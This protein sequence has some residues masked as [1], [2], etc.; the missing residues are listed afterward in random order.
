MTDTTNIKSTL[1]DVKTLNEALVAKEDCVV[2]DV[3][4]PEEF[5]RGKILGGINLPVDKVKGNIENIIPNKHKKIFIYCQ[6]GERSAIAA[7]ELISLGYDNVFDVENG[8][9]A[10]KESN[11]PTF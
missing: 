2:L 1:V 6:S 9:L 5:E 10:W 7:E 8:I 3:R 11:F 4:T